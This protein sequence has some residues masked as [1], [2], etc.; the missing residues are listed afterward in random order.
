MPENAGAIGQTTAGTGRAGTSSGT[1]AADTTA[2]QLP[3]QNE[4]T[5]WG[6]HFSPVTQPATTRPGW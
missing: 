5:V 6:S 2:G 1:A 3:G 4:K